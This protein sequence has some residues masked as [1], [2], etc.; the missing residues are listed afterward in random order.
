MLYQF[1]RKFMARCNG[2]FISSLPF[3]V[4]R[5]PESQI[6]FFDHFP[7]NAQSMS[8][9]KKNPYATYRRGISP[10][11]NYVKDDKFAREKKI[12]A[13]H[14]QLVRERLTHC[15]RTETV[16]QFHACKE[17]REQYL[18]LCMDRYHGM[19]FP[20]GE[21]P[22]NRQVPGITRHPPTIDAHH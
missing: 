2:F 7:S 22:Q 12:A 8:E 13:E 19:L 6:G 1:D 21:E 16:N 10:Y 15:V 11:E 4:A 20:P 14:M 9:E 17:L 5:F 3:S 18:E